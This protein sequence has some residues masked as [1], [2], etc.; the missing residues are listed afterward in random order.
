MLQWKERLIA[1]MKFEG[2]Q[3]YKDDSVVEITSFTI[4]TTISRRW[5]NRSYQAAIYSY[6]LKETFFEQTRKTLILYLIRI[7]K[8]M[9]WKRWPRPYPFYNTCCYFKEDLICFGNVF[10]YPINIYVSAWYFLHNSEVVV[11]KRLYSNVVF[12]RRRW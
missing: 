6:Q 7:H 4:S 1:E 5:W 8:I 9:F 11:L 10:R 2:D 3:D 12:C